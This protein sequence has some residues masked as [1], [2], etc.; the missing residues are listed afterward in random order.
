MKKYILRN[1]KLLL[2]VVATSAQAQVLTRN[3]AVQ[4]AL[5]NNQL[6]KSAE[7]E[8]EYF[9]QMKKTGS[10]LG[11]FAAT[12]MGG[13]YNSSEKDNN[14]NLSQSIPFPTAIAA[15]SKLKKEQLIGSQIKLSIAQ[16]T[17]VYDV[18][19]AYE[20]LLYQ[21]AFYK[22]LQSQDSLY[23]N[24]ARASSLRYKTGESNL[25]EKTTAETQLQDVKNQLRQTEADIIILQTKLKTLLKSEERFLPTDQLSKLNYTEATEIKNPEL[26]YLNQQVVVNEQNKRVER[27]GLLPDI[28]VGYFNQSL[29]G[30]QNTRGQEI[31]YDK[32]SRFQGF[33]LGVSFPLWLGPQVGRLKAAGFQQEA[34]RQHA[35]YFQTYLTGEI[36][37]A[38]LEMARNESSLQYYESNALKNAD[39]ILTQASKAYRGG[40]IGYIE[41]LQSIKN[42][43]EIKAGYLLALNHYN[44]SVLRMDFL[45]GN[46]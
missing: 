13:Q 31:Y 40:E 8:V 32:K 22:L 2:I 46:Y 35:E 11:K 33:E 42:A 1:L 18:Q 4:T 34:S 37:Q 19:V 7:Y 10:D 36:E 12:W 39:L 21:Q 6:I 27:S 25:L 38:K 20:Q 9:K 30:F 3:Q 29:V 24:F 23:G 16:N 44:L 43:R 28:T 17:L 5:Q 14:F 41:F 45:Q 15:H 26:S